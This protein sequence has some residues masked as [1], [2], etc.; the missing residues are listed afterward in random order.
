MILW[1]G[2]DLKGKNCHRVGDNSGRG[3]GAWRTK[4]R[5]KWSLDKITNG[6]ITWWQCF[7]DWLY[8]SKLAPCDSDLNR[9]VWLS[10]MGPDLGESVQVID[11]HLGRFWNKNQPAEG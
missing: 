9:V 5:M 11:L 1:Q 3:G 2:E 10:M 6:T 7:K 4:L 8:K